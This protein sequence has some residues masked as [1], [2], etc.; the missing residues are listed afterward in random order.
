MIFWVYLGTEV[1]IGSEPEFRT[2]A[3]HHS[4]SRRIHS[5]RN[6][7]VLNACNRAYR[8]FLHSDSLVQLCEFSNDF[9]HSCDGKDLRPQP[10]I[11]EDPILIARQPNHPKTI[12]EHERRI[13]GEKGARTETPGAPF[14]VRLTA[15]FREKG[16][17]FFEDVLANPFNVVLLIGKLAVNV[18]VDLIQ[19]S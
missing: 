8:R 10:R 13:E 12:Q 5:N 4:N 19:D 17:A 15:F 18:I 6:S 2:V 3:P 1:V 9:R 14:L 7:G 16:T 11:G